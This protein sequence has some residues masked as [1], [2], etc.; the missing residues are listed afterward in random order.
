MHG[1]YYSVN[2]NT[3]TSKPSIEFAASHLDEAITEALERHAGSTLMLQAKHFAMIE[4]AGKNVQGRLL[5][6]AD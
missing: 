6:C 2:G 1:H 5:I 4:L 3:V